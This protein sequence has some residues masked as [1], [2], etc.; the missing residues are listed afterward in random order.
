MTANSVKPISP[1]HVASLIGLDRL[2]KIE[3][4][5]KSVHGIADKEL[6]AT[7]LARA[8]VLGYHSTEELISA[9][10]KLVPRIYTVLEDNDTL[11]TSKTMGRDSGSICGTL[12]DDLL[13]LSEPTKHQAIKLAY[14][15]KLKDNNSSSEHFLRNAYHCSG[16]AFDDTIDWSSYFDRTPAALNFEQGK[17]A[18]SASDGRRYI[19]ASHHPNLGL[20]VGPQV[21]FNGIDA[22]NGFMRLSPGWIL[23]GPRIDLDPGFYI[24]DIEVET[25]EN[26]ALVLDI[27]SNRGLNK[28]FEIRIVGDAIF[29]HK[30]EI[31]PTD[32][33]LEVRII[34]ETGNSVCSRFNKILIRS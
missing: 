13:E 25:Q 32:K 22:G 31:R 3:R 30:F 20:L 14:E 19:I 21:F 10:L 23:Y 8:E 12:I 15:A 11:S 18:M 29:C 7:Y 28:I 9:T 26:D 2:E 27:V 6:A 34:N 5:L 17:R 24:L 4:I 1:F 16:I 33:E